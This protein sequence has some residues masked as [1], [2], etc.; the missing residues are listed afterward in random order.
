MLGATYALSR[1]T[2]LYAEID[3]TSLKGN[4]VLGAGT[5]VTEDRTTGVSVGINTCSNF[6]SAPLRRACAGRRSRSGK[7]Y[8][9]SPGYCVALGL[10]RF[11]VV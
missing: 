7:A 1:R 3:S 8:E 5:S 6:F 4:Q 9:N 2:N 10:T 11:F